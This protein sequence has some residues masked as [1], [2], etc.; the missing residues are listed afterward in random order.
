MS[1]A[2]KRENRRAVTEN[3]ARFFAFSEGEKMIIVVRNV[4]EK[5]VGFFSVSETE[6]R[7]H[8]IRNLV[9]AGPH[10]DVFIAP[11]STVWASFWAATQYD[12]LGWWVSHWADRP[13]WA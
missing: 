3:R 12:D 7:E 11:E 8:N 13:T 4:A 2:L 6:Y 9:P 10:D 1:A 5:E